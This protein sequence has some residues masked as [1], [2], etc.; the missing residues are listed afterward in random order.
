[1]SFYTVSFLGTAP[2]G[3]LVAGMAAERIG[4]PVT[5]ALGGAACMAGGAWFYT[6]LPRLRALIRPVYIERG[7]LPADDPDYPQVTPITEIAEPPVKP[8]E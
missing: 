8:R 5:I 6:T 7:L 3:S 2:I 4:A 1:M